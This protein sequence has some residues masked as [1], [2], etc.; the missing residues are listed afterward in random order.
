ME[1]G[2][3][4]AHSACVPQRLQVSDRGGIFGSQGVPGIPILLQ[5]E[6][7]IRTREVNGHSPSMYGQLELRAR[8]TP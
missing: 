7:E 6:P 2:R 4:T 5:P 8:A 3:P 1:D